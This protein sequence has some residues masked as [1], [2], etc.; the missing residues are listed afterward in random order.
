MQFRE[1]D[2]NKTLYALKADSYSIIKYEC[3]PQKFTC[4]QICTP[5]ERL[6]RPTEKK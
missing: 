6:L 3:K 4:S 5:D 2:S 1:R